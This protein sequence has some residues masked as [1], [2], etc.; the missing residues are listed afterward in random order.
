MLLS[1]KELNRKILGEYCIDQNLYFFPYFYSCFFKKKGR[2]DKKLHYS[3]LGMLMSY[4]TF[5]VIED[6]LKNV[7]F[8]NLKTPQFMVF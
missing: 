4:F 5:L 2:G 1:V 6:I 3:N 7:I 8:K